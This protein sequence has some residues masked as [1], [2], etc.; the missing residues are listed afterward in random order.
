MHPTSRCKP[1]CTAAPHASQL[2]LEM[3]HGM[4]SA[5]T[6][7]ARSVLVPEEV[8]LP[9]SELPVSYLIGVA[10]W[11]AQAFMLLLPSA[12]AAS[13]G[14][15]VCSAKTASDVWHRLL[16]GGVS[17]AHRQAQ[18]APPQT[19]CS[20]TPAALL[21][22]LLSSSESDRSRSSFTAAAVQLW[23]TDL[24]PGQDGTLS[25]WQHIETFDLAPQR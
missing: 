9:G 5:C 20:C 8:L 22:S 25:S 7:I 12:S 17:S 24:S 13:T 6:S 18:P 19:S 4:S 21:R 10:V 1:L 23:R 15:L 16:A 11:L 14:D 3:L 2:S